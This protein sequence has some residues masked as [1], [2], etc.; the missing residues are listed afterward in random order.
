MFRNNFG[1]RNMNMNNKRIREPFLINLAEE[2]CVNNEFRKILWTGQHMQLTVMN[3]E[4]RKSI[5]LEIHQKNDHFLYIEEGIGHVLMGYQKENLV[6]RRQVKKGDVVLIPA[7]VWHNLINF[8]LKPI[9]LFVV[10]A[11]PHHWKSI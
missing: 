1:S 6:Y 5:G 2:T 8:S 7:G 9:K 10:Y 4:P 11:P 3:I